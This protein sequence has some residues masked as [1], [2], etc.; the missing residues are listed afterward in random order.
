MKANAKTKNVAPRNTP[1]KAPIRIHR[2][3]SSIS[4]ERSDGDLTDLSYPVWEESQPKH[5]VIRSF[6]AFLRKKVGHRAVLSADLFG[7]T[8]L[9]IDAPDDDLGIGQRLVD[10]ASYFDYVSPMVYPSHYPSG[11]AGFVNPAEHPYEVISRTLAN[12][13]PFLEGTR[14]KVRP[15]LQDFD[16]GARYT[17]TM[18]RAQVKAAQE[19]G[20]AGWLLWNA[21]NRYTAG[22]LLSAGD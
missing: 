8:F 9:K 13:A 16:L 5:E 10:A 22:A 2:N 19:H 3:A 21:T 1:P 7:M 4:E 12:A 17:P 11:F 20:S 6:F 14:T 18:I 15:W